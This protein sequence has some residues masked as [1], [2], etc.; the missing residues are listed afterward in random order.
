M[1]DNDEK[2]CDVEDSD[3]PN[4][5]RPG[6]CSNIEDKLSMGNCKVNIGRVDVK[7]Q[8]RP[9]KFP[10]GGHKKRLGYGYNNYFRIQIDK[11]RLLLE[12]V[13]FVREEY[14]KRQQVGTH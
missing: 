8:R 11:Q 13:Q 12:E 7:H 9:S 5:E 6:E 14:S 3:G 4:L 2:D 1:S 10:P